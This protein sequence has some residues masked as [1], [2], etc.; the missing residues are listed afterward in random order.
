MDIMWGR[1]MDQEV[2]DD[3]GFLDLVRDVALMKSQRAITVKISEAATRHP[4]AID[5][6]KKAFS[7]RL[8]SRL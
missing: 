4:Y 5:L 7:M 6:I 1:R 3:L 2:D 8:K